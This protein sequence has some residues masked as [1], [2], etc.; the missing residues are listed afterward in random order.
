MCEIGPGGQGGSC[1]AA[2]RRLE[3]GAAIARA[4]GAETD[5][6]RVLEL[7]VTRGRAIVDAR[8][9]MILLRD[10]RG[11]AVAAAA[12][13]VPAGVEGMHLESPRAGIHHLGI[14]P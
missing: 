8:G 1:S 14:D 9:M 5:L 3:A 7:I 6:G 12:G 2:V 11:L 13:D 10:G 4:V